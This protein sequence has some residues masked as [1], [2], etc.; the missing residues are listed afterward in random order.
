MVLKNLIPV[1]S[2]ASGWSVSPS[3]D[4]GYEGGQSVKLTGTT[5]TP[6]VTVN[7]IGSIP[8]IPSHIYYARVYG[9]QTEKAGASVGFYWPIAEPSIKEGIALKDAGSWQR[10]SA[11]T[12]RAS[13]TAG[14]YQFRM[15]FNNNYIAGTMYFDAPMLIDLTEAFGSGNEPTKSWMDKNIPFFSGSM[16]V[17]AQAGDI[18]NFDYTGAAQEV[19]LPPGRYKLEA[20]GAQGGYRSSYTYGGKGGYSIGELTLNEET[21]IIS[22]VGGSGNTGGTSGGYNGGGKRDSY[23]GGGGATDFRIKQD[24]LLAR[25]LVAGGGGSDGA[26][27]KTGG[28]GGGTSG[29]S[30]TENYGTGGYGGT[31]TGVSSTSWQTTSRPTST[32]TQAG[33]YAGFGFGGNGITRSSGY[34]GA[35]GGG[36]YGGSG[37]Y[38]DSSGDDDRG[39]G[40]GSGFVWTGANAPSGY[41]LGAEYC[42]TNAKTIAGNTSFAGP[43]GTAETG[44]SGN[45]Y[46][47]I[48][49][50]EIYGKPETPS[51]F[52]QIETIYP[53]VGLAW[54]SV[55]NVTGYILYR[56]GTQ[57][58][59]QSGTTYKETLKKNQSYTY[60]LVAYNDFGNSAPATLTVTVPLEPPAA[61]T[62]LSA[63]V[64]HG[65]V[66]LSW[67]AA[68]KATGYRLY[69][70]G[71]L[72]ADQ[73]VTGYTDNIG[74]AGEYSYTLIAYN[75]DGDSPAATLTVTVVLPPSAPA[76][77]RM[78]ARTRT[79]ISLAWD[80]VSGA[81]GYRLYRDGVQIYSGA[82]TAHTDTGLSTETPYAYAVEAFNSGGASTR[83]TLDATT[84]GLVLITDRT[85]QDVG[86]IRELAKK[87]NV[88]TAT[89]EELAEWNSIVLKGSY[90]Y[91]DLNRVGDAVQYLSEILKSHGYDCPVSPKLDW[92]ESGRGAPSD[93]AQYLQNVQTLRG[94]LTLLPETPNV[95]ADMEKLTWQEANAIEQILVDLE[96]TIKT[97]LKTRVACGDAYCGGEYL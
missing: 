55:D 45:G 63:S 36:W 52:R 29:Q 42:L 23:N 68:A 27:N 15:D 3:T 21:L 62:G 61:P 88:G 11:R 72:L 8:L 84:T 90:D 81:E 12:D 86:R 73:T 30:I 1:P 83:V 2:M 37:S 48:T 53:E 58:S 67:N 43:S 18:L 4:R 64:S 25:V 51:N 97:M 24:S 13:F 9:Y 47:R 71:T 20:W 5:S 34:G 40:G 19:K 28:Y 93:M 46:A 26:S 89:V 14:N 96:S 41:L 7:T 38:P 77:L 95:P 85:Q 54:D 31:Q 70:D 92:S 57:I 10:Y 49:V 17:S 65:V 94:I 74:A 16:I 78:T 76:E 60:S 6:E 35:G 39:G 66:S 79:T 44:H 87:L 59:D 56:D 69:R 50:I 80:A 33:A 75:D 91:S 32:T 82:D 22:Q